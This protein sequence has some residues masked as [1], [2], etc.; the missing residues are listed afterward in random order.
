MVA[1]RFEVKQISSKDGLAKRNPSQQ[2]GLQSKACWPMRNFVK[3]SEH[4]IRDRRR[5][6]PPDHPLGIRHSADFP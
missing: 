3:L 1:I 5:T 2:D 6:P 4:I